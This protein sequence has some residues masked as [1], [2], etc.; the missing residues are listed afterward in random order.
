MDVSKSDKI[1][2]VDGGDDCENKTVKR[3]PLTFKN[4][5][6]A[7]NYLTPNT[8]QAFCPIKTSIH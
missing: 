1:G 5:N 6:V 2:I 4:L 3:S 8:R 7:T